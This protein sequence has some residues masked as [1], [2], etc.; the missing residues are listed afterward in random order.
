MI[1]RL[2]CDV[3]KFA[4]HPN[5][6][7]YATNQPGSQS[8]DGFVRIAIDVDLPIRYYDRMINAEVG[9]TDGAST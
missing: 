1:V 2:Y 4:T 7:I 3:P 8:P 9:S 6:Y 5:A